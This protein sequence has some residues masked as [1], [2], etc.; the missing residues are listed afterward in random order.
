MTVPV[1][2]ASRIVR[3]R[4]ALFRRLAVRS[5]LPEPGLG[6]MATLD[7][8]AGLTAVLNLWRARFGQSVPIVVT[9]PEVVP[10]TRAR[11]AR[12]WWTMAASLS[13][14]ATAALP[15]RAGRE[16]GAVPVARESQGEVVTWSAVADSLARDVFSQLAVLDSARVDTAVSLN[17]AMA[18]ALILGTPKGRYLG[19]TRVEARIDSVVHLRGTLVDGRR[20]SVRG[21]VRLGDAGI[22]RL[23]V[24]SAL[25]RLVA[26]DSAVSRDLT[27]LVPR[28]VTALWIA[29]GHMW[30]R[31]ASPPDAVQAA[32]RPG[33]VARRP[34]PAPRGKA[35][36]VARAPRGP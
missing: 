13:L 35:D 15:A 23:R 1:D 34:G 27:F 11:A 8:Q 29:G 12:R 30:M 2:R 19:L 3:T 5:G 32:R 14:A 17:A 21:W 16:L 31:L 20:V 18:A 26:A 6:T 7:D 33:P 22:G 9:V 4:N 24:T 25:P 10:A 28:R 36:A